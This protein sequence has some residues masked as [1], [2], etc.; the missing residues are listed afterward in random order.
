M[1]LCEG[2]NNWDVLRLIEVSEVYPIIVALDESLRRKAV[3][4]HF[5]GLEANIRIRLFGFD[6]VGA[7]YNSLKKNFRQNIKTSINRLKKDGNFEIV[8][9]H[10]LPECLDKALDDY[11]EVYNDS[12]KDEEGD[13]EFHRKLANIV[14][15]EKKLRLFQLYFKDDGSSS[16]ESENKSYASWIACLSFF[17]PPKIICSSCMSVVKQ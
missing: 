5:D 2:A 17:S 3:N 4:T 8:I 14:N 6:S 15:G 13:P 12:W 16:A 1:L 11:Y 7:D 9:T 10:T